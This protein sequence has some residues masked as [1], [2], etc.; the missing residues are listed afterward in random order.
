MYWLLAGC[1]V[2][3]FHMFGYRI[4]QMNLISEGSQPAGIDSRASTGV[5][6][7]ARSRRQ[8][9]Q[10]QLLCARLLEPEPSGGKARGL[11][12]LGIE[13]NNSLARTLAHAIQVAQTM[14]ERADE[15]YQQQTSPVLSGS[16]APARAC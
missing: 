7:G 12:R 11:V 2:R 10:N 5:D 1:G 8:V 4:D 13:I 14:L 9:A 3:L 16:G 6:D 15:Y